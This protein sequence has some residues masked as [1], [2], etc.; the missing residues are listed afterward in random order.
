MCRSNAPMEKEQ[1]MIRN[2]DTL[3]KRYETDGY[4]ACPLCN[5]RL[6][7]PEYRFTKLDF[8]IGAALVMATALL[9]WIIYK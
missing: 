5:A 1:P 9:G 2:C 7:R 6:I 4:I 8:I 3:H